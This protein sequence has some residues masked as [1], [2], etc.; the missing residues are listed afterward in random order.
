MQSIMSVETRLEQR[1]ERG[2]SRSMGEI[3]VRFLAIFINY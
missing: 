2:G 1:R 3:G